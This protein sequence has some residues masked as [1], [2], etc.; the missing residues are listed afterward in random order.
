[1]GHFTNTEIYKAAKGLLN[2]ATGYVKNLP[3]DIKP[4]LGPYLCKLCVELVLLISRANSAADKVPYLRDLLERVT[5]VETLLSLCRDLKFI[6]I[7]Q[8]AEAIK[9]TTSVGKQAN[10]WKKASEKQRQQ[11]P[12][13]SD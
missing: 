3:R 6:S 12:P 10:G 2:M 9:F 4:V 8:Y 11:Q 7:T 13:V 1:M 5:E